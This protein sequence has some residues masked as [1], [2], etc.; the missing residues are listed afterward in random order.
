M[1]DATGAGCTHSPITAKSESA[2]DVEQSRPR[3][4]TDSRTKLWP[5]PLQPVLLT[6]FKD[7]LQGGPERRGRSGVDG[8]SVPLGTY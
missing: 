8:A 2:A 3:L 5:L 6:P 4:A 1:R 7:P